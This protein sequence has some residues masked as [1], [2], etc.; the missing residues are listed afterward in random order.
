MSSQVYYK[1]KSSKEPSR[2]VFDGSSISVFD[3]KREIIIANKLG[4]GTEFDL[5]IYDDSTNQEF[6]DDTAFISRSTSVTVRRL[7]ALRP[8]KGTAARYV[9]GIASTHSNRRLEFA[10][11]DVKKEIPVRILYDRVLIDCQI[12]NTDPIGEDNLSAFFSASSNQWEQTQENLASQKKIFYSKKANQNA[13]VPDKP[14]PSGYICYRCGEK[15]HWIQACPT[16]EDPNFDKRQIKRTTGIPKAFLKTIEKPA[17]GGNVMVNADGEYVVARPDESSWE[18]YRAKT[19]AASAFQKPTDP[20]LVCGICSKLVV[21]AVRTP[22]CDSVY[23]EECIHSSLFENDFTCPGCLARDILLDVLK[24]DDDIRKRAEEYAQ[25]HSVEV[26]QDSKSPEPVSKKRPAPVDE[27]YPDPNIQAFPP[28]GVPL[29]MPMMPG[30]G[31]PPPMMPGMT[32]SPQ[33]MMMP[34][35]GNFNNPFMQFPNQQPYTSEDDSPY[36]RKPVNDR[37]R[38]KRA[39]P[40]D[41]RQVM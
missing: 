37:Q 32:F 21:Q 9:S 33:F 19:T 35:Y 41:Y 26:P 31:M 17:E 27:S 34:G 22:C 13:N 4:T 25:A 38:A 12:P 36:M 23:C 16:N 1:F 18:T 2:V 6:A 11:K 24:V 10:K 20:A 29:M 8:G 39:R 14:T 30:I 7:P 5:A 40:S 28:F 3:L 15:G